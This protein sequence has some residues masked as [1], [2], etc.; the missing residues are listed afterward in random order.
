MPTNQKL[1]NTIQGRTVKSAEQNN[2]NLIIQFEDGS[3]MHVRLAEP[4]ASV[5]VRDTQNKMEY[6]D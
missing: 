2:T 6:A 1:T 3:T 5:M 4:T